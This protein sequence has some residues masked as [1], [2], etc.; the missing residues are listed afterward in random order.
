MSFDI[1]MAAVT[2]FLLLLVSAF[3]SGAETGMTAT[4]RARLTE[5]KRRGSWRATL[6]LN[7]T[8]TRERLIGAILL[9][10]N[11]ANITASAVATAILIK[12]FGDSGAVIASAA[13][14]VLVLIFG[15]VMPKTYAIAYPDRVA[16]A[17]APIMRAL[18]AVFGPVVIAVEY[19]VKKVLG[20]LGANVSNVNDVL[21]AHD[22]LRGT[23]DLHYKE[24]SFITQ[25]RN[26]LGGIL[27]LQD[28]EVLDAMIH[29]TKMV[30]I[31]ASDMTEKIVK[32]VLK[33]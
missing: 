23:I 6:V 12:T 30:S 5:M 1:G 32:Q 18:V 22:E 7:L 3:F 14:T 26:M 11:V 28:L 8:K 19:I 27:D 16:L 31:D 20:V 25:D 10:N 15:E 4:S 24:G 21:S 9:G 29:R 2:I 13:M 33:S 17:V